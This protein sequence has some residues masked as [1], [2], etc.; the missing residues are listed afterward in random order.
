MRIT[1]DLPA[2][3]HHAISPIAAHARK[4]MNQTGAELRLNNEPASATGITGSKLKMD[5]RTGLPAIRSPS[6]VSVEDVRAL[7]DE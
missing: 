6:P 2:D 3:L 5:S 4:S 1:I 7:E